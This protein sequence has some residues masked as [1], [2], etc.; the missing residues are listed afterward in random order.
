V[1]S[2]IKQQT[3]KVE[4]FDENDY[5]IDLNRDGKLDRAH[6]IV[7]DGEPGSMKLIGRAGVLQGHG[8]IH[9]EPGLF[10]VSTEFFHSL[11]YLAVSE[12]GE[13][14]AAARMKEIRYSVK[15]RWYSP[16]ELARFVAGEQRDKAYTPDRPRWVR[17]NQEFGVSNSL[18]WQ[19]RG[20]IEDREGQLRPQTH[21]ELVSCVGCHSGI[22]ATTDSNFS[23]ARK[24]TDGGSDYFSLDASSPVKTS[25]ESASPEIEKFLDEYDFYFQTNGAL[26][27][28]RNA[29][30]EVKLPV[31]RQDIRSYFWPGAEDAVRM[32]KAYR[33]TVQ[34]QSYTQGREPLVSP[35]DTML[36][37]I[38]AGKK[39]GVKVPIALK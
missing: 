17:G 6:A 3:I 38:E 30:V 28:F 37:D 1:E 4:P 31:T 8:R 32:N 7:F 5:G 19:Y 36:R 27:D 2:A 21:Q 23:F 24:L 33:V 9:L 10:P 15:K 16:Q 18:A 13:V 22:G 29:S 39:T 26:N 14:R 20:F 25:K 34:E 11:R 35:P 12:S